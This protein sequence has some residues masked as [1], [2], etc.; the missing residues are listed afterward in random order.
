VRILQRLDWL[1][2]LR[3][4]DARDDRQFP[5]TN[6]PLDRN[7]LLEEMHA[8][9]SAGRVFHGFA[10][11]RHIAWKLPPLWPIAPFL[12][13]PGVPSIGQR[14]YLWVARNRFHLVPCHD[15]QCQV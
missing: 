13:I 14:L 8:V 10:A 1:H 11:F 4:A 2:R 15:G 7:R 6:P 9:T 12:Y 5:A 3:F